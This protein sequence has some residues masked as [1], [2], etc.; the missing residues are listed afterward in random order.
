VIPHVYR[1]ADAGGLPS[2][3]GIHQDPL[4]RLM[5][6]STVPRLGRNTGSLGI[7]FLRLRRL[8]RR[9]HRTFS[10]R[11]SSFSAS[12][13]ANSHPT[14]TGAWVLGKGQAPRREPAEGP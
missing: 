2:L 11:A 12:C 4:R 3:W 14:K 13:T 10:S 5:G 9:F 7:S 6:K 8:I 1:I